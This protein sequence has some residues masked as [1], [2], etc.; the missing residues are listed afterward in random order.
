MNDNKNYS[1]EFKVGLFT[2]IGI[3][4][5]FAVIVF[6]SRSIFQEKG[7]PYQVIFSYLNG[8]TSGGSVKYAGGLVIGK[9]NKIEPYGN[10]AKVFIS[11][12]SKV[13]ITKDSNLSIAS[14]GLLGEK[15]INVTLS[16]NQNANNNESSND[17]PLPEN[18]EIQGNADMGMDALMSKVSNLAEKLSELTVPLA[19]IFN[20]IAADGSFVKM[21]NHLD[22]LF[23]SLNSAVVDNRG[24]F[25]AAVLELSNL[26]HKISNG[27]GVVSAVLNDAE[28]MENFK[29][30]IRNLNK[31]IVRL[32]SNPV[33]GGKDSSYNRKDFYFKNN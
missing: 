23:S 12:S 29:E 15:Y 1:K 27:K 16:S 25:K 32:N 11:V 5:V 24:P 10:K 20:K 22:L 7:V 14:A 3:C 6:F 21:V 13:K 9:I 31:L 8:L 17:T 2:F 33:I 19:D 28:M 18:T 30:A 4:F 26:L